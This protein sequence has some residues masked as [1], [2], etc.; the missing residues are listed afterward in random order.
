MGAGGT[1]R[2]GVEPHDRVL[3][4]QGVRR[5]GR[6]PDF[7]LRRRL[8]A[9]QSVTSERTR[10]KNEERERFGIRERERIKK[11][12]DGARAPESFSSLFLLIF[13]SPTHSDVPNGFSPSVLPDERE[14]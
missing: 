5:V 9:F 12:I 4:N 8:E 7:S 1:T 13:L 11:K 3:P 6:G 2:R 10:T 14:R